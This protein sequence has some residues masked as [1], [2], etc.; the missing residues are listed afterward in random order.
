MLKKD[1]VLSKR[2][3]IFGIVSLSLFMSSVDSTIVATALSSI[4]HG[5]HA[6]LNW[7]GWTITAYQLTALTVMPLV[8]RIS[9]EWGRKRIFMACMAI[10]TL[11]SLLAGLAT[12]IHGLI[13]FRALQALGGGSFMPSAVGIVGD[14][15]PESRAKA[16]GL[17]T[18]IF[19]LG[20]I[21]G[22]ALGGW[23][24]DISSWRY[25]FYV[26]IPIGILVLIMSYFLLEPDP[27]IKHTQV[28]ILGAELFAGMMLSFMYFMTRIGEDPSRL[29]SPL[30][31]F[32]ILMAVVFLFGFI[33]RENRAVS[34]ILEISLLKSRSFVILN[35][36]NFI[37]G[38]CVFGLLAFIP[39]YSQIAYGMTNFAS[40]TLL[41]ARALGM[42]GTAALTS[43]FLNRTGYRLPMTFGFLF[44]ALSI[45]SLS[46]SW[47]SVHFLGF[48]LTDFWWL[49]GIIFF[50]GVGV[51]LAAPSSN[52]AAI[53]L[54]PDKISAISGLRGMF[55]QSGGVVGTSTVVLILSLFSDKILG[56]R[57]IFGGM[58]F[59]L[60]ASL[61]LIRWVPNGLER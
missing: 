23:I 52:N 39:Y 28:D 10:F 18:S 41:T 2:Y 8:G 55:R 57:Y 43:M 21:I 58:T 1:N 54:M 5:L 49:A 37:Y 11:S 13:L 29:S 20:G 19:P 9:D 51:G 50:S 17:F 31:W 44:I 59:I 14:Y 27:K 12:N 30:T 26:N 7:T 22:P 56:F 3:V 15:F 16:I 47:H 33:W 40:G 46:P 36:L 48:V 38:I 32:F 6:N 60:L 42:I 4:Q 61:T 34:P 24:L 45:L 35:V 53:E 25:I